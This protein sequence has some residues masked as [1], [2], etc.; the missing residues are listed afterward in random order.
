MSEQEAVLSALA[1]GA[2]HGISGDDVTRIDTHSAIIFLAGDRAYK[3][4][5][6]VKFPYLDF[7]TLAMRERFSRREVELNSRT[8]PELY[9]GVEPL[10]HGHAGWRLGG[11]GEVREWVVVMRRFDQ[12]DLF[13]RMAETGRL[14]APL[15][16]R[17][18]DMIA[19]F[20]EAA[21]PTPG[22]DDLRWVVE[23]NLE[24]LRAAPDLFGP[25]AVAAY[26]EAS[27]A[28]FDKVQPLLAARR[29]AGWVRRGHGDLHLHNICLL[30]GEPALFDCI[31][32]NDQLACADVLYDFAFLL[33]DLVHRDLPALANVALG[34]YVMGVETA[35]ALAALSL[36]CSLRAAI[37]AKVG[38][39]ALK[40]A[41]E[42]DALK[43]DI[44]A[45][46]ALARRFLE[47]V[48]PRLVAVG[49]L[50][51]TGKTTLAAALAPLLG[52]PLG[53]LHL[54]TDVIRKRLAGV[55]DG[56][57]LPADSYTKA[58]SD[59]VYAEMLNLAETALAAGWPVIADAVFMDPAERQALADLAA[60][61]GVP[62]QGL[63]LAAPVATLRQRVSDRQGDA[64]DA[65]ADVVEQ[66]VARAAPVADWTQ[67]DAGGDR[68]A[69]LAAAREALQL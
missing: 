38:V 18:V 44:A 16:R 60:R 10:I 27:R 51:G 56:E 65:T 30:H 43:A 53:A 23:E 45:Y 67:V 25:G 69:T 7:S 24:E 57:R 19:A 34:R 63:W 49:G 35:R 32:F 1:A 13:D 17:A 5:R 2:V 9:L 6:A 54:R 47:P 55:A 39:P 37:R 11:D 21:E 14:D 48:P 36:F 42:P 40:S 52:G 22:A 61:H 3:V 46:F 62:C 50:S 66:Q 41:P 64:S 26:A 8:A 4:K 29:K 15:M 12:D 20:H 59:Q 68:D 28:A 58:A 31:E 33:M